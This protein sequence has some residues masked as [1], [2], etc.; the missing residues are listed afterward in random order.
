M[1]FEAHEEGSD[2]DLPLD[3][4]NLGERVVVEGEG[5]VARRDLPDVVTKRRTGVAVLHEVP[6]RPGERVAASEARDLGDAIEA[7]AA[8][9][10]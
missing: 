10:G 6:A 8:L 9:G 3:L 1:R 7:I 5:G 4:V 2:L